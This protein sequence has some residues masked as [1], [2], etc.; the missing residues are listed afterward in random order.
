MC[1]HQRVF[2]SARNGVA[3]AFSIFWWRCDVDALR[4]G[5][6]RCWCPPQCG[7]PRRPG[8]HGEAGGACCTSRT[9]TTLSS[10]CPRAGTGY[11]TCHVASAQAVLRAPDLLLL[12]EATSALGSASEAAVQ[13]AL[14][15]VMARRSCTTLMVAHRLATV[16]GAGSIAVLQQ[17]RVAEQ[18]H[19]CLR[20]QLGHRA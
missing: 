7:T 20:V 11:D 9:S 5:V 14:E 10:R 4:A 15:D 3:R 18:V 1:F 12:D 19:A 13:A 6:G 16:R 2:G 8:R 17:G